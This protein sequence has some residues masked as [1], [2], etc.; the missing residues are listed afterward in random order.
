M[1]IMTRVIVGIIMVTVIAVTITNK[2]NKQRW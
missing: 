2:I 1:K